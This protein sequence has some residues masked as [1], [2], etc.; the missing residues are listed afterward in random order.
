MENELNDF[1]EKEFIPTIQQLYFF[2]IIESIKRKM[3]QTTPPRK[4]QSRETIFNRTERWKKN[5]PKEAKKI[6]ELEINKNIIQKS[7]MIGKSMTSHCLE[8]EFIFDGDRTYT[9][10]LK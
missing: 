9:L 8:S 4:R 7:R 10:K 1:L 5:H 6:S 2:D 3:W